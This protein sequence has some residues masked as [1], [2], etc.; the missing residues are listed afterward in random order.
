MMKDRNVTIST[1]TFVLTS[2]KLKSRMKYSEIFKA[3][4]SKRNQETLT[5]SISFEP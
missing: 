1:F 3:F 2:S 5:I 4:L